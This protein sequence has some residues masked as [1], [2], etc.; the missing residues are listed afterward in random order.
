MKKLNFQIKN[1]V[2]KSKK[3]Q[4]IRDILKQINFKNY[5]NRFVEMQ[6]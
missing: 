1:W 2:K 3:V 6:K 5:K 4:F